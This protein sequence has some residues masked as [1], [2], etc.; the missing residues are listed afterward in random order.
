MLSAT[1]EH[2]S[3]RDMAQTWAQLGGEQAEPKGPVRALPYFKLNSLARLFFTRDW[4]NARTQTALCQCLELLL[5]IF[6][7]ESFNKVLRLTRRPHGSVA[8]R[9]TGKTTRIQR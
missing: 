9:A 3:A 2:R 1:L 8:V 7:L 4:Q 5:V 6:C